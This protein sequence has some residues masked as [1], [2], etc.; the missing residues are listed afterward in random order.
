MTG[1]QAHPTE[2][3]SRAQKQKY[4]DRL[5]GEDPTSAE[6]VGMWR[7]RHPRDQLPV[8]LDD[9]DLALIVEDGFGQRLNTV[10]LPLL[11]WADHELWR[12][13]MRAALGSLTGILDAIDICR[14]HDRMQPDWLTHRVVNLL[15]AFGSLDN[16]DAAISIRR[17]FN[18]ET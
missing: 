10:C 12:A 13:R 9:I 1:W 5:I 18:Q 4:L 7:D 2:R 15:G 3:L 16:S 6:I 8:N 14:A 17:A 11:D